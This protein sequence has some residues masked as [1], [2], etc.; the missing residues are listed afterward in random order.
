MNE[1]T[2]NL[3]NIQQRLLINIFKN[4]NKRYQITGEKNLEALKIL[5]QIGLIEQDDSDEEIHNI[6]NKGKE[7]L[8]SYN[9]IDDTGEL[10]SYA[11]DFLTKKLSFKDYL[12]A[13][14][15]QV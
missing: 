1:K 8:L 3:T 7:H 15:P 12:Q 14:T 10:T 11:E 4:D 5:I 13:S 6:T 9:F 2:H